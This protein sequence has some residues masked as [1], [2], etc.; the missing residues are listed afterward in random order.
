MKIWKI[1]KSG[2]RKWGLLWKISLMVSNGPK[3]AI[4]LD[5]VINCPRS[6]TFSNKSEDGSWKV[7]F[8]NDMVYSVLR[9]RSRDILVWNKTFAAKCAD[10]TKIVN[11]GS[12][13]KDPKPLLLN[14]GFFGD[15]WHPKGQMCQILATLSFSGLG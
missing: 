1:M 7:L 10:S 15:L 5:D 8:I 9:S 11:K 13:I 6:L 2:W 4:F 3:F 12:F 14:I